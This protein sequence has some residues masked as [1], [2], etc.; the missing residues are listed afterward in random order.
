MG[1][2][3]APEL[4]AQFCPPLDPA[5]V[6]AICNEPDQTCEDAVRVLEELAE[7]ARP[8]VKEEG[9]PNEEA[10]SQAG[11]SSSDAALV[12]QLVRDWSSIS[13]SEAEKGSAAPAL[14]D[15]RAHLVSFLKQSFPGADEHKLRTKLEECNDDVDATIDELMAAEVI[16]REA[17]ASSEPTPAAVPEKKG[18][19]D[20]DVLERGLK[21]SK[22]LAGSKKRAA[23]PK[24]RSAITVSLTDQRAPHHIYAEARTVAQRG[25]GA[26]QKRAS[27]RKPPADDAE[28][29]RQI[30]EEEQELA[31]AN[32]DVPV[33]DQHW[34]LAHSTLSQLA[35]LLGI[36]N[37]RLQSIFNQA[38]FNLHITFARAI[39]SAAATPEAQ[40]RAQDAEFGSICET[41][42]ALMDRDE[43]QV[44]RA[45]LATRG[46]Q[47]AAIDLLQLEQLVSD[48]GAGGLNRPDVLDPTALLTQGDVSNIAHAPGVTQQVTATS[49]GSALPLAA[50]TGPSYAAHTAAGG[51]A[52][53]N[54]PR[55]TQLASALREGQAATVLPASAGRVTL[56]QAAEGDGELASMR[57]SHA[58]CLQRAEEYR[59]RRNVALRQAASAA[60]TQRGCI[61]GAASVYA[62][63]ARN[64]DAQA[65]RWQLRAA[66]ALVEQRRI[67][68]QPR[69]DADT[70]EEIDLHGLTAHEAVTVV[71]AALARWRSSPIP[72]GRSRRAPLH[73][74]TGRGIHSRNNMAVV[75]PAVVRFLTQQGVSFDTRL[76]PGILVVRNAY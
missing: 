57:L 21:P 62:E 35:V 73:I 11:S 39:E 68:T 28:L 63:E 24:K 70:A 14:A 48:V 16:E 76:D 55:R 13:V 43:R 66:S 29:A 12:D 1:G 64:S 52:V 53:S 2:E 17:E 54:P 31:G 36:P 25:R 61:G 27:E 30:Q 32:E 38:S 49:A 18:G 4:T 59:E 47:D 42:A 71:Q 45:L 22:E 74:V 10:R 5:L 20:M 33:E 60:R 67:A 34:L 41:L 51:S 19:L 46:Q 56:P 6:L 65:R 72:E 9:V 7:A 23:A 69:R 8:H 75:R 37:T 40:A 15:P 50:K 44:R 3:L 26:S 58:E